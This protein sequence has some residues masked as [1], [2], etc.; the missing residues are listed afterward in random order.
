MERQV[1]ER[2]DKRKEEKMKRKW[3]KHYLHFEHT[4]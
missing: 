2:D 1:E 3:E 4:I